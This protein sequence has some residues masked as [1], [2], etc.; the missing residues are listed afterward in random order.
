[1]NVFDYLF[2]NTSSLNK[3][4]VLGNKEKISYQ[5][6]YDNT[7]SVT[8]Q[9]IDSF[10]TE[11]N[12][13]L[14]SENSVFFITA[15]LAIMKSGNVCV[16]LNPALEDG[17]LKEIIEKTE[18]KIAFVSKRFFKKLENYDLNLIDNELV[19]KWTHLN[20]GSN[21]QSFASDFE[22]EKLA[23]IIFTSGSTGEQKGV[24][25]SHKNLIANTGS[26]LDYLHLTSED[27][28][29]I[30]MP[31]Y[32]CYGLSLLHTHLRI[33]GSVVLNNSFVFIGTV[34]NDLNKYACTGFSGVLAIFKSSYE[35]PK[36]LK[37]LNSKRSG[38]LPR[39]EVNCTMPLY[40]N[41]WMHFHK[42]A[43]LL[44]MVKQR[45]LQD[46]LI[47]PPNNYLLSLA[48]WEKEYQ[49]WSYRL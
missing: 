36:I 8:Q 1:M 49:T 9:I 31:F 5:Q 41:F 7:L 30:V 18:S 16:P 12:I 42:S 39:Q 33:G 19:E 2:E 20:P 26:I 22:P 40:R 45:P 4:L 13:I 46:F 37:L 38:M 24:M 28:I 27:T 35:K 34:I 44:C 14:L 47:S 23:Q 48:P 10:G 32:Y 21:S 43:F 29:L 25:L 17:S 11:N 15:Y 3:N 6:I